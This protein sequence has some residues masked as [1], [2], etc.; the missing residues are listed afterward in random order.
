MK[1]NK[2]LSAVIT[3]SL[4]LG[5]YG[6]ASADDYYL[7][8]MDGMAGTYTVEDFAGNNVTLT[9]TSGKLVVNE[10]ANFAP[11]SNDTAH[12]F[13]VDKGTWSIVSGGQKFGDVNGNIVTV[14]NGANITD[15][16]TAAWTGG[17][18]RKDQ[19]GNAVNNKII[20]IT[21]NLISKI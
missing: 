1:I 4:M 19:Y 8:G 5:V 18:S 14:E 10:W 17:F 12:E 21:S 15:K 2:K 3:L 13:T 7:Y 20:F 9:S 16:V 6:S 11:N